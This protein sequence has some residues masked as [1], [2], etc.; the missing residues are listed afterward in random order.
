MN[1]I[2]YLAA[3]DAVALA[4]AG[5]VDYSQCNGRSALW[6][7]PSLCAD[8]ANTCGDSRVLSPLNYEVFDVAWSDEEGHDARPLH[9]A[10]QC[11]GRA[12]LWVRPALCT[13]ATTDLSICSVSQ[14]LTAPSSD[15]NDVA[16][17]RDEVNSLLTKFMTWASITRDVEMQREVQ[18]LCDTTDESAMPWDI[19]TCDGDLKLIHR[20]QPVGEYNFDPQRKP[21]MSTKDDPR[22]AKSGFG[23]PREKVRKFMS[24]LLKPH[25]HAWRKIHLEMYI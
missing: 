17:Q 22:N 8:T 21:A 15:M 12:P 1:L 14:V 19:Q 25:P 13:D 11:N 4:A 18:D 20:T 2:H 3:I 9:N 16:W 10:A 5:S 23:L 7:N 6:L 24:T